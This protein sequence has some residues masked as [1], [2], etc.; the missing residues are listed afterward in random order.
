MAL[1]PEHTVTECPVAGILELSLQLD[2]LEVVLYL[3]R[4]S[5]VREAIQQDSQRHRINLE[6]RGY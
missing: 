2:M 1:S 4:L 6:Q 5:N 3:W